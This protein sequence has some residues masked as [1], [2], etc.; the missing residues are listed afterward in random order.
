MKHVKHRHRLIP[1]RHRFAL[2]LSS[3]LALGAIDVWTCAAADSVKKIRTDFNA[4]HQAV[5]DLKN[6]SREVNE[7]VTR[8]GLYLDEVVNSGIT[9]Y[10]LYFAFPN[11]MYLHRM[12]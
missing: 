4:L 7:S 3:L 12:I 11:Q 5:K 2:L 6:E 9:L 10:L 1:H 8:F